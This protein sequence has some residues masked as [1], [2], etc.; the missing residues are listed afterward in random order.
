[1]KDLP[2]THCGHYQILERIGQGGM[3][4]LYKARDVRL[5]RLVVLKFLPHGLEQDEKARQRFLQEARAASAL[6][7][8]N[9]CV[10]HEI[11][12]TDEGQLYIAMAYYTGQTLKERLEQQ[13]LSVPEAVEI[14]RQIC[15][16]L[17]E[18][19]RHGVIHRDIKPANIMLTAS[20]LVKI[21]DFGLARVEGTRITESHTTLGTLAYMA[22]EQLRGEEVG[23]A[24][25]IWAL[26]VVLYEMITGRLPFSQTTRPAL[27]YAILNQS[28]LPPEEFCPEVPSSLS[29]LVLQCLHKSPELRPAT[30]GEIAR[31]LEALWASPVPEAS[32]SPEPPPP[33]VREREQR[34]A[35]ILAVEICARPAEEGPEA[36][37]TAEQVADALE[38]LRNIVAR[39]G[40]QVFQVGG[41]TLS[42]IFGLPVAAEGTVGKALRAATEMRR[43]FASGRVSPASEMALNCRI[44]LD[45]GRVVVEREGGDPPQFREVLGNP[46]VR[47]T[48]LMNA[49]PAG[50]IFLSAAVEK[51]ARRKYRCRP[52]KTVPVAGLARGIRAF[53][54]E[55]ALPEPAAA[56]SA[57]MA[58]PLIGRERERETLLL[59]LLKVTHG[60]GSIVAVTGEAGIGKSRLVAEVKRSSHAGGVMLLEGQA[61]SQ[62]R[63]W[64]YHLFVDLFQRWAGIANPDDRGQQWSKL[65]GLLERVY[66]ERAEEVL[67]FL[68]RLLQ[69]ELPPEAS[70][71]IR[72]IEGAALERLMVKHLRKLFGHCAVRKPLVMVLEDLQWADN[73][74]LELLEGLFRLVEFH[75]ILFILVLRSGVSARAHQVLETL[76]QQYSGEY[77][78]A[79]FREIPLAPLEP[80][81]CERLIRHL[82]E[83]GEMESGIR[84]AIVARTGGNPLFIEEVIR[85]LMDPPVGEA[86]PDLP[87]EPLSI[88]NTIQE[89]LLAR[90]DRLDD[91]ARRV[92]KTAAVMGQ[93]FLYRVL[94]EVVGEA[95]D[96]AVLN[97]LVEWQL[98]ETEEVGGERRYRFRHALVQEAVYQSILPG[99]RRELHRQVARAV[100]KCL[101]EDVPEYYGMLAYHYTR[102]GDAE[103]AEAC[104]IQ[105]GEQAL[106]AAASHEALRYSQEALR[107]YRRRF[108][109]SADREKIL[110]LE[111]NIALAFY[112]RGR[113]PEA[114][115]HFDEVLKEYGIKPMR[116][117]P[118]N[119]VRF[120][121]YLIR[122]VV[123][124]LSPIHAA[125]RRPSPREVE[126]VEL[127]YKRLEALSQADPIRFLMEAMRLFVMARRWNWEEIP[128]GAGYFAGGSV[129]FSVSGISLQLSHRFLELARSRW[130]PGDV[131]SR[132]MFSTFEKIYQFLMGRWDEG[133][134]ID[135]ALVEEGLRRGEVFMVLLYLLFCFRMAVDQ[136]VFSRGE[137]MLARI[138]AFSE[139]YDYEL[140]RVSV[141]LARLYLQTGRGEYREILAQV[142]QTLEMAERSGITLFQLPLL[143]MKTEAATALREWATAETTLAEAARLIPHSGLIGN[144]RA[145]YYTARFGY[146]LTRWETVLG[147]GSAGD[148]GER[149]ALRK[150]AHRCGRQA[151]RSSRTLLQ[152]KLINLKRMGTLFWLEGKPRRAGNCW[153]R[154]LRLARRVGARP[155]EARLCRE[156]GA[157][158]LE[159]KAPVRDIGGDNAEVYLQ[160]AVQL[161]EELHLHREREEVE[162]LLEQVHG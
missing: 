64:S 125:G 107:I 128:G 95:A 27:T 19:H 104:L 42:A 100:G 63:N 51:P 137:E 102:A 131:K 50:G 157:R 46:V 61:M 105:A 145:F 47:A 101:R 39:H 73:S 153:L 158:L 54:L 113:F 90:V 122:T 34:Q 12:E 70:E 32:L 57:P 109:K 106:K 121:S 142:N 6:D 96:E 69:V 88:P 81:Q 116:R 23:P 38:V 155:V 82:V 1:M 4:V 68:G 114:V 103:N 80:S 45:T 115:A 22:P 86:L 148:P 7:H 53:A 119:A 141:M 15:A 132:M 159:P 161:F 2:S 26:G 130:K 10:I 97:R 55:E 78:G 5:G 135:E 8:P 149:E 98:L 150:K 74:S 110:L 89:M 156:I 72:G 76:K 85:S 146:Y 25:D 35:T 66:P 134:E 126:A 108:G 31:Q 20:G 112:Y 41:N 129:L 16:G 94:R 36:E 139:E 59:H 48:H 67:P 21:V 118:M 120:V 62:G 58:P 11:D 65:R 138:Q 14:A 24:A 162:R 30:A 151:L 124:L 127:Q 40:G 83:P 144:H 79:F 52:E 133:Q 71:R 49:A 99:R 3:G 43:A 91:A 154:A 44:G 60:E 84:R 136:G 77:R 13:P 160:Q 75:P 117:T 143:G 93:Q 9:I 152:A 17:E 140:G 37:E 18:A 56:T 29:R 111:R 28:P 87:Q 147:Q 33:P 92:L 123:Y